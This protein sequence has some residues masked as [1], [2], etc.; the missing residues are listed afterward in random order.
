MNDTAEA[1]DVLRAR[2]RSIG[3]D[4]KALFAIV[5][6]PE[7]DD[8]LR[9]LGAAA[10]FYNL[11]PANLIPAKEGVL[12]LADDAIAIRC[13]LL[14]VRQRAPDRAAKHADAAPETWSNLEHE[15]ALLSELLGPLWDALRDAWRSVGM[16]EWR[17]KRAA[18]AVAD[19]EDS[20][21][22]YA[23]VDEALSL[24]DVDDSAVVREIKRDVLLAKLSSRLSVRKASR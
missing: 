12:G 1:M 3:P 23:A 13:A 21:W 18:D 16:L 20:A 15:V 7:L 22:L 17:G 19:P 24:R 10:I 8:D 11:N 5:D 4:L 2:V 9:T 14:E 6:D